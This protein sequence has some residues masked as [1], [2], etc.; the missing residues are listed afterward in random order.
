MLL[1]PGRLPLF[2]AG[3]ELSSN[4]GFCDEEITDL[5]LDVING[6]KYMHNF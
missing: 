6:H 2:A 4:F 3:A 5:G 1:R